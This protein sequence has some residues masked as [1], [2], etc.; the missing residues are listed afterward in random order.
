M[1]LPPFSSLRSGFVKRLFDVADH[2]GLPAFVDGHQIGY[3]FARH[4]Q[5]RLVSVATLGD[6]FL[7]LGRELNV[8]TR[9]E[10]GHLDQRPL[11][12]LVALL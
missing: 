4:G 8:V 9:G 1:C 5:G 6:G 11:K 7:I 3:K 10:F 12:V 2:E